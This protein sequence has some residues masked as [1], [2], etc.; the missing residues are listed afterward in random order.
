[1][2][3]SGECGKAGVQAT[4]RHAPTTHSVTFLVQWIALTLILVGGGASIPAL[5]VVTKTPVLFWTLSLC[6]AIVMCQSVC[7]VMFKLSY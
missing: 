6:S 5:F 1:M 2:W 3:S 4:V 7:I